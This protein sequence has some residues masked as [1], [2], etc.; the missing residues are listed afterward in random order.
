M[1]LIHPSATQNEVAEI[2]EILMTHFSTVMNGEVLFELSNFLDS[3]NKIFFYLS[4]KKWKMDSQFA[5]LGLC[6]IS[7]YLNLDQYPIGLNVKDSFLAVV[8]KP[9]EKNFT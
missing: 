6:L 3:F 9:R 4:E 8:Q 7:L 1:G 2:N 5:F